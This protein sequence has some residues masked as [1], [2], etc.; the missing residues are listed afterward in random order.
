MNYALKTILEKALNNP[1]SEIYKEPLDIIYSKLLVIPLQRAWS[2][3]SCEQKRKFSE[4]KA[5]LVKKSDCM[6]CK[7]TYKVNRYSQSVMNLCE[8][9]YYS[10]KCMFKY[11]Y[12]D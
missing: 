2:K 1:T 3:M 6:E 4:K 7:C 10:D 12:D 9:C 5:N 11:L 8:S